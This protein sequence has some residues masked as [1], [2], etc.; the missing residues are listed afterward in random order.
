MA[1]LYPVVEE[2]LA[3]LNATREKLIMARRVTGMSPGELSE[4][5]GRSQ[6]FVSRLERA[7]RDSP[8]MST[9]QDWASGLGLRIEFGLRDFWLYAHGDQEML[10]LWAMSRP[11][12]AAGDA[13]MR[14]WIPSALSVWRHKRGI[15]SADASARIGISRGALTAWELE[16]DDPVIKRVMVHARSLGTR[17]TMSIW[18]REDW[19][20]E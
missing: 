20:F 16:A 3:E 7:V 10:A 19:K 11:W 9:L 17:L 6:D 8:Q 2:D 14:L 4:K 1:Y 13:A 5:I 12:G 15:S 18:G